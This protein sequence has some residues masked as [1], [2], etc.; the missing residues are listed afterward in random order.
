MTPQKIY[1][2]RFKLNNVKDIIKNFR[3]KKA[4][5]IGPIGLGSTKKDNDH[6]HNQKN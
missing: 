3:P 4:I 6:K 5:T 2:I 1:L